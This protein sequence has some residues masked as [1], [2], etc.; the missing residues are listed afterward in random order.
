MMSHEEPTRPWLALYPPGVPPTIEEPPSTL[1]ALFADAASTH[2]DRPFLDYFGS[3][4]TYAEA[5]ALIA[6]AAAGFRR[7]GV[8][9]GTR[10]ALY[11]PNTSASVLCYFAV[12]RA[13]GAVVNINPL[14]AAQQV[15]WEIADSGAEVAV[16]ADLQPMFGRVAEALEAARLRHVVV[17]PMAQMLPFPQ[18]L[19]FRLREHARLAH[20]PR[21]ARI[22]GFADLTAT[23]ATGAMTPPAPDDIAVVQ[24][25]GGTTGKPKGVL[26]SHASLCANV[27][28]L[29]AWFTR[30]EP[31]NERFLAVLPFCHAFGMTAVMN[32]AVALGGE[33]IILPR[34]R[35]AEALRAI[36]RRRITL[37]VGVPALF[38]ALLDSPSAR[39]TDFSSLK[40][41]VC[42]GDVL[43][44]PL[45]GRFA[46]QTGVALA[47]GYGLTECGPVAT[48]S[49]PLEG[50]ARPG[51]CG[52][53]LPGT[54]V[55]IVAAEPPGAIVAAEP[56]GAIMAA[57]PPGAIM[58]AEPPG[59]ML[60][61]GEVG[62]ICVRGP[63]LMRGYWHLPEATAEALRDGWLHTG[64]LGRLD[65]DGYLYFA[66]RRPEVIAV[67]GY[68]VY[69]RAVEDAIRL[70]PAVADVAVVGVPDPVRGEVPK[71]CIVLREDMALS[72]ERLRDFLADRLSPMEMPRLFDF[73]PSLPKSPFGKVL[74]QELVGPVGAETHRQEHGS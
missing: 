28:Q 27:R 53:P 24:Y 38:Q 10:V 46:A 61:C 35:P 21:D 15:L 42:G 18:S 26:L 58:P 22:S 37:L 8:D 1:D 9:R 41:G 3:R 45:A 72:G 44:A 65:R 68:K 74:K 67:Q 57:E 13:G 56:P 70:H 62:E 2:A 17:C 34:F 66:S 47:E 55:A 11:L 19:A 59:A 52:V 23:A 14:A 71:A 5:A 7:L 63:Q 20:V 30:A 69:A 48:C 6:R 54:E 12:L 32:F 4:M 60:P 36:E 49:N 33:L 73:R 50:I 29:R 25:T 64:D 51:S 43:P 31:G 39:R 16:T 40:V